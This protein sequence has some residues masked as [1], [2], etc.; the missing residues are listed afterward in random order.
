[1]IAPEAN[2]ADEQTFFADPAIDRLMGFV[3]SLSAEVY[4]L[5]D[6]LAR[7]EGALVQTAAIGVDAV[8][9]FQRTPQQVA[10]AA[11]DRDAFV[12]ALMENVLG[13]QLS[14]GG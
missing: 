8:E 7:L 11:D 12:A 6:R 1:M 14:K 5:R 9:T 4:V 2:E 10:E 13:R 3:Y